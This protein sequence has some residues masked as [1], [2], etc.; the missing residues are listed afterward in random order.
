MQLLDSD[1]QIIKEFLKEQVGAYLIIIFG[2]AA[3]GQLRTNSDIDIAF[4]NDNKMEAK[5]MFAL[6]QGLADK[7][8]RDVD[9]VDLQQASTVFQMQIVSRGRVIYDDKPEKRQQLFMLIFKQYARLNEERAIVL[10]KIKE[11]GQIYG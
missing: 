7:L 11:R 5:E 1:L 4:A 9:L 8:G 6:A 2:S 10:Q 3:S